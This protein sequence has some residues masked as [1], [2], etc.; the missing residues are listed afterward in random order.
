V[1]TPAKAPK[2]R[3]RPKTFANNKPERIVSAIAVM[4]IIAAVNTQC[5][6]IPKRYLDSQKRNTN[7]QNARNTKSQSRR[8]TRT[9]QPRVQPDTKEKRNH[10]CRDGQEIS[11]PR[12]NKSAIK[13]NPADM[14]NPGSTA[15][16]PAFGPA[17]PITAISL[18]T[19]EAATY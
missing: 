19:S 16:S 1:A 11:H 12:R 10:K 3:E 5:G 4:T 13:A 15:S 7:A 2:L 9:F 8:K 6:N 17:E 18:L 14:K